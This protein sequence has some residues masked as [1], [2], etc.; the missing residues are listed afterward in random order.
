MKARTFTKLGV[1][2]GCAALAAAAFVTPA[3]ADPATGTYGTLV[4]LGSDTTQSVLNGLASAIS[5]NLIAS[6]DATGS[7]T[8][9]FTRAGGTAIPRANGSGAGLNL[10]AVAIGQNSSSSISV[11]NG[12]AG[13]SVSATT[14]EAA[15]NI[16]FAR[17][18]SGPSTT[19]VDG[20]VTYI[21][22]GTDAVSYATAPG[23]WIP[24]N[25]TTAQLTSIYTGAVRYVSESGVLSATQVDSTY[26]S[27]TTFLPQSGSGTRS[28]WIGKVGL[29]ETTITNNVNGN[30]GANVAKDF[31]G[32]SVQENDGSALVSG[33]ADQNKAAIVPF[34]IAQWVAQANGAQ[35]DARHA[36]VINSIDG[37]APTTGSGTAYKLNGSFASA[38]TRLV[39]N[40]VPTREA[41]DTT[42][43]I[44]KA[45]V[46]TSS[47]VCKATSTIER[48][49]FAALTATTGTNACGDVSR[50][51]LAAS[52]STVDAVSVPASALVGAPLTLSAT[53]GA[54]NGDQGGTVQFYKDSV[55]DANLLASGTVAVGQRTAT[56]SYTPSSVGSIGKVVALFIPKLA[57]IDS[58]EL[59]SSNGITVANQSSTTTIGSV[60]AN[61]YG[62]S[63][64]VAV[65]VA[66]SATTPAD[67]TVQVKEGSKVLGSATVKNGAATVTLSKTLKAGKHSIT[68]T[69]AGTSVHATSTSAAKAFSV[70]KA[71]ATVKIAKVKAVKKGKTQKV[72]VTVTTN[73]KISATGTIQVKD[74]KKIVTKKAT[75]KKGKATITIKKVKAGKHSVSVSY[76]GTANI[77]KATGKASF[78]IKK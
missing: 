44:Y 57:G 75:L 50:L 32:N 55:S 31:A 60:K 35:T 21:P 27:I 18:S 41:Q 71:K 22:F 36:V 64:T 66:G 20:V 59:A 45:F 43:N 25:L 42:S 26:H 61:A 2:I 33:T 3:N 65:T 73:T 39:Y 51:A 78:T 72:T 34:S 19:V 30:L 13:G 52:P 29:T 70:A 37:A 46:G 56:A 47:E 28:F 38:F 4:G 1:G 62:K 68:A 5:G 7:G 10:L 53:I 76:A 15:G 12:G 49:G 24:S 11:Y 67:G 63:S 40:I 6:Y 16:D 74:G 23:S 8:T 54:T 48:Y 9:V 58:S 14:A 17:S 69:Y 77:A